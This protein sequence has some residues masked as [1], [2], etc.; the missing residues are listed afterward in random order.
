FGNL[1]HSK[2]NP[3]A[4]T[5]PLAHSGEFVPKVEPLGTTAIFK[6]DSES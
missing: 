4:F 3:E 1:S 6:I 2:P 5:D